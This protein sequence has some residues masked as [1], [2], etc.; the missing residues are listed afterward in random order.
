MKRC[1]LH[2][3]MVL[4]LAVSA[5]SWCPPG[6]NWYY[7]VYC[8][9]GAVGYTHY[10][11]SSDTIIA[12]Q[13]CKVIKFV[14]YSGY[15]GSN[16]VDSAKG[17][18]YT[19]EVNDTVCFLRD[20]A[21]IPYLYFNAKT[22]DTIKVPNE[23]VFDGAY[24][25]IMTAV[26]DSNGKERVGND[27]LRYYYFHLIDSCYIYPAHSSH[28]I[29]RIGDVS[30]AFLPG[31]ASNCVIADYCSPFFS[32][33]ADSSVSYSADSTRPC[34]DLTLDVKPIT[35]PV[36]LHIEPNPASGVVSLHYNIPPGQEG[37]LNLQIT[38]LLGQVVYLSPLTTGNY[39]QIDISGFAA[40]TYLVA[41]KRPGESVAAVKLEVY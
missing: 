36:N 18:I 41:L 37:Q 12:G 6:A 34:Y 26:V 32:C 25:N 8:F 22:G 14:S 30:N 38:N 29:E 28:V 1:L 21:F 39:W 27:S 16:N 19:R 11:Y 7:P 20:S 9:G 5:Q 23:Q 24:R 3:A 2:V 33:Y 10:A 35:N 17:R 15:T 31:W 4:S 13:G 40:G